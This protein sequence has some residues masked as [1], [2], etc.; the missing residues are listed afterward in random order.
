MILQRRSARKLAE[1]QVSIE[2]VADTIVD[3]YCKLFLDTGIINHQAVLGAD[4]MLSYGGVFITTCDGEVIRTNPVFSSA[5]YTW[6][7]YVKSD[8]EHV[9]KLYWHRIEGE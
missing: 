7:T 9:Y 4:V 5:F 3:S 8:R 2:Q 6:S 1:K